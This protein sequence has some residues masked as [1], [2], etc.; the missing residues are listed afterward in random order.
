MKTAGDFER[1]GFFAYGVT[2]LVAGVMGGGASSV[3][4]PLFTGPGDEDLSSE[5]SIMVGNV[6]EVGDAESAD[7]ALEKVSWCL[8][9]SVSA[10]RTLGVQL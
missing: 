8:T 7:E 6:E 5:A 1:R 2:I 4:R 3:S 10:R 9:G